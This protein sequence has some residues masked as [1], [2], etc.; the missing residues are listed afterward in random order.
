MALFLR[1]DSPVRRFRLN[2]RSC[3]RIMP[4][5]VKGAASVRRTTFAAIMIAAV[6]T[7]APCMARG[8]R[9]AEDPWEGFNRAAFAFN[10][11]LDRDLLRPISRLF[12]L[13]AG[14]IGA[15]LHNF[16]TNLSEPVVFFNDVL[17]AR[18]TRAARTAAR[19]TLNTIG[20]VV[21]VA[22]RAGIPH[23]D[24]GFGVTLGRYGVG[25]GP[26]LFLPLLGPST[27][28]DILGIGVDSVSSPLFWA[29]Y[30]YKTDAG[31]GIAVFRGV[32]ERIQA[33]PDLDALVSDA[34]DPYA[35]LRSTWLQARQGEIDEAR[36]VAPPLPDFGPVDVPAQ[37]TEA[38]PPAARPPPDASA[39]VDPPAAIVLGPNP[40]DQPPA[41][42]AL[43][44]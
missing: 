11:A 2:R 18:P 33:G 24:N 41:L 27:V 21:D 39:A 14:P 19:F 13:K 22:R 34:A 38:P 36:G 23:H 40:V 1:P 16:L 9:T 17:Q 31:L 44:G 37:P 3:P 6:L 26:Y 15:A 35:T 12:H 42:E 10:L 8:T 30:P 32:D 4:V 29:S 28:R 43:P 7:G 5:R 25:P 20:G